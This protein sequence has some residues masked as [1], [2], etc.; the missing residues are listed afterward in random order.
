MVTKLDKTAENVV[1]L[2]V[3]KNKTVS[4]AES[5]TGGMIS[6]AVTGVSGAS[7]VFGFGFVTYANEAKMKLLGTLKA[8]GAVSEETACQMAE[9]A[10]RASGSDL[11][12]AVTGI[13][14][15]TGG[16]PEKPVGT[17]WIGISSKNGTYAKK[18]LFDGGEF[19]VLYD[20]RTAV[21]TQTAYT[22]LEM[23]KEE[24]QK[25]I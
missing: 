4:F 3:E 15:P 23:I 25:T 11:A 18:F 22:A 7:A 14:G 21:R 13:A 20:K 9:G 17:V 1:Q 8:V 6:S 2:L 12:A 10:R 24:I 16:T 19:A 5:C